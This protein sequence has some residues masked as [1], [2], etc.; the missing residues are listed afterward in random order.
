MA[1]SIKRKAIELTL[2]DGKTQ[3]VVAEPSTRDLATFLRAMPSLAA[4]GK[5]LSGVSKETLLLQA[6]APVKDADLEDIYPLLSVMAQYRD[7]S[8]LH[9]FTV[10]EFKDLPVWDSI[11]VLQTFAAFV[12]KNLKPSPAPS[13][14]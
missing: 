10:D 3:V 1:L 2:S 6:E 11:V 8:G 9:P 5:L 7:E 4:M 13:A 12:P 14:S